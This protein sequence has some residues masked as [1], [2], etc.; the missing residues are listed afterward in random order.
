MDRGFI[1]NCKGFSDMS[2]IPSVDFSKLAD[3]KYKQRA[4]SVKVKCRFPDDYRE[5]PANKV[6]DSDGHPGAVMKTSC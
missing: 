1:S 4:V 3:S 5:N 2:V 6:I